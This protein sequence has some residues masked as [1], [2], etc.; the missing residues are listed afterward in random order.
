MSLHVPAVD[1]DDD[2]CFKWHFSANNLLSYWFPAQISCTALFHQMDFV[3]C[4]PSPQPIFFSH[5]S[6]FHSIF[7]MDF[8]DLL[9]GFYTQC[10]SPPPWAKLHDKLR[11]RPTSKVTLWFAYRSDCHC[12]YSTSERAKKRK[13]LKKSTAKNLVMSYRSLWGASQRKWCFCTPVSQRQS[14]HTHSHLN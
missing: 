1:E 3:R 8:Q 11:E 6:I 12:S 4:C 10:S 2:R 14:L 13:E 9:Y 5:V 7:H